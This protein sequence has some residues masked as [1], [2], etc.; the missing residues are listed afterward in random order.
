MIGALIGSALGGLVKG[1][2]G[3]LAKGVGQWIGGEFDRK[4]E[5]RQQDARY[6][7]S[8]IRMAKAATA[9]GLHPLEVLRA[10]DPQGAGGRLPQVMSS[11]ARFGQ[12]DQIDSIL[13][14]DEAE[15]RKNEKLRN[16]LLRIQIDEARRG[17]L[18]GRGSGLSSSSL[19]DALR[20]QNQ[21]GTGAR[22]VGEPNTIGETDDR[23]AGVT[24]P[25]EAGS[26]KF[27]NPTRKDIEDYTARHG[28]S[29]LGE[30]IYFV[31]SNYDDWSY[32]E[33]LEF[34]ARNKNMSKEKLHQKFIENPA[35]IDIMPS[36]FQIRAK[37]LLNAI[38]MTGVDV[39]MPLT[40]PRLDWDLPPTG[41][42]LTHPRRSIN[43]TQTEIDAYNIRRRSQ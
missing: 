24:N 2:L 11:A 40:S 32:N 7:S 6:A 27:A 42:Q 31:W 10:G 9:A 34:M 18:P 25:Y 36:G 1:K 39:R 8:Y 30:T 38:G 21:P 20:R 15:D 14:G 3:G 35:L 19:Q 4:R 23:P 33:T 17:G 22:D 37:K 41:R 43:P 16:E 28:D 5:T 29:E 13:Q 26:D 12:F